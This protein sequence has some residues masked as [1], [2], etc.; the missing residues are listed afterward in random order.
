MN[1]SL[2]P[3]PSATKITLEELLRLKQAERPSAEF[4]AQF[5]QDFRTKQL[6]AAV[7]KRRW[8]YVLPEVFSGLPRLQIPLGA[9]AIL[10]V[11]FLTVR[12]YRQPEIQPGLAPASPVASSV[13]SAPSMAEPVMGA[14]PAAATPRS[15]VAETAPAM[16]SM[17]GAETESESAGWDSSALGEQRATSFELSPSARSIAANRAAAA[18][19]EP[20]LARLIEGQTATLQLASA[21]EPLAEVTSPRDA[22]RNRLFAYEPTN[23]IVSTEESMVVRERIAS[24]LSEEELYD[25]VRRIGGGGDRFTLRF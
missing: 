7:E 23:A 17:T 11:T 16:A 15:M 24:R 2:E 6:A 14:A 21:R 22:R 18:E 5:E 9:A 19:M 20:E 8:W 25:Q 13:V 3:R 10:A 1:E 12:E 4:W